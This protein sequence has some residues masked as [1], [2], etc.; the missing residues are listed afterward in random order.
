MNYIT[1]KLTLYSLRKTYIS[2]GYRPNF[3][4]KGK[5][6]CGAIFPKTESGLL[7]PGEECEAMVVFLLSEVTHIAIGDRLTFAEGANPTGEIVVES[8]G[9]IMQENLENYK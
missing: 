7:F 8:I 5:Y 4:V 2:N 9:E 3:L 6:Y 1:G